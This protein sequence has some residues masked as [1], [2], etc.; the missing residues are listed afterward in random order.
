[1]S[2]E[3]RAIERNRKR[4]GLNLSD[5]QFN[6][7]QEADERSYKR[8]KVFIGMFAAFVAAVCLYDPL[9]ETLVVLVQF[10]V[11]ALESLA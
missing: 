7:K 6:A 10:A 2:K 5:S 3:F 8:D 11:K 1:M 9:A 4:L